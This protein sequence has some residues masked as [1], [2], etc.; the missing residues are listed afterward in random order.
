MA[1]NVFVFFNCDADKTEASMN[2]FYNNAA[3]GSSLISRRKLFEKILAERSAGRIKIADAD[4]KKVEALIMK[5]NPV[6]A[7]QLIQYGAI[8]EF[9]IG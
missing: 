8:K 1:N 4:V 7:S 9:E 2:I 5:G 3:Y 6:E